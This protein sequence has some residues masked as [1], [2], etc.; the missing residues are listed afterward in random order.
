MDENMNTFP[1]GKPKTIFDWAVLRD[2]F[3]GKLELLE[4]ET[5]CVLYGLSKTVGYQDD[6]FARAVAEY[7]SMSADPVRTRYDFAYHLASWFW[8]EYSTWGYSVFA[9]KPLND[10][11]YRAVHYEA[12][13]PEYYRVDLLPDEPGYAG[14]FVEGF[15]DQ[16][17]DWLLEGLSAYADDQ[18]V[19]DYA[20]YL[21]SRMGMWDT[22]LEERDQALLEAAAHKEISFKTSAGGRRMVSQVI[23]AFEKERKKKDEDQKSD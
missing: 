21:V 13:G 18:E 19:I 23:E 14:D 20:F 12:N 10:R 7:L 9:E 15:H 5:L 6:N 11:P 3:R 17:M 1:V 22:F 8:D 4:M 2:E 16:V